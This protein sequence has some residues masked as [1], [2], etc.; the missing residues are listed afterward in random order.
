MPKKNSATPLSTN[1]HLLR[2]VEKMA[3]LCK[4]D[5]IHWVDGSQGE[6]NALCAQM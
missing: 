1:K 6:Y 2:W 3:E 4:P 5:A